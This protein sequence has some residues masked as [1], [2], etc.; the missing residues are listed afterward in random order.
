MSHTKQAVASRPPPFIVE[1]TSAHTHTVI[2]LHGLGSNGEKFGKEFIQTG[3]TSRG[4]TLPQL[5]PGAKFI[6]PTSKQRRS[7]A[8]GRSMLT[9]WFDIVRLDDPSYRKELQLQGLSEST[10]EI[11]EL[12]KQECDY[13]NMASERIILG[14]LSQG[15]ATSL[16]VL[17][18]LDHSIGGFIGMSGYLPFEQDVSEAIA[19]LSSDE[20][21]P[22]DHD[23]DSTTS[24]DPSTK[25][26]IFERD[27]LGLP[28]IVSPSLEKTAQSTPIFLGHGCADE[29]VPW[30]LGENM[31][32]TMQHAG[33]KVT[34][35]CYGDQGHWYKIPEEID[36][37]A[38]FIHCTLGWELQDT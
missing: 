19:E 12:L 7:T 9:Q 13:D 6:F 8:F 27:L 35:K 20:D 17:L 11:L 31:S 3:K 2:L 26:T 1:P 5:L 4:S 32:S 24:F 21:N 22:F 38:D 23:D 36:D 16:S 18:C 28:A 15:C 34:W 33:Y 10:E 30:S 14:G 29:K 25:A 37:I